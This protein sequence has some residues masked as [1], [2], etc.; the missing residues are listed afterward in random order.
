MSFEDVLLK[1][2]AS[3]HAE[4][5]CEVDAGIKAGRSISDAVSDAI[6]ALPASKTRELRRWLIDWQAWEEWHA[7]QQQ[8]WSVR[9]SGRLDFLLPPKGRWQKPRGARDA[10]EPSE[11]A[12]AAGAKVDGVRYQRSFLSKDGFANEYEVVKS[13]PSR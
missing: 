6:E 11:S 2:L 5:C 10:R 3:C 8:G 1:R 13:A 7:W 9:R 4:A 12:V